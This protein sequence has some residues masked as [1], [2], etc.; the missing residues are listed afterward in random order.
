[1]VATMDIANN[2]SSHDERN[3]NTG[4]FGSEALINGLTVGV[5]PNPEAPL[6]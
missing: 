5:K 6:H 1:M 4:S 2:N 3:D